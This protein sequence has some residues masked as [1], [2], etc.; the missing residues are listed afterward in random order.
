MTPEG[1]APIAESLRRT[2]AASVEGPWTVRFQ[3]GRGAP[4]KAEFNRLISFTESDNEGIRYFSG[5]AVYTASFKVKASDLKDSGRIILS[6]GEVHELASVKLNGKEVGGLWREPFEIDIT[7]AVKKGENRVEITV[8]NLWVNRII[9]DMQPGAKKKYTW[10]PKV[11][12][13]ADSQLLPS[14]LL[15]PVTVWSE[16]RDNN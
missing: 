12:Y 9:G 11:F 8:A 5:K 16:I 7:S 10:T 1:S 15:G 4:A 13:K 14:G 6:L 3:E 2:L